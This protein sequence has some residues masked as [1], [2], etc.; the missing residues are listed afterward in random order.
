MTL[1]G[2]INLV[3]EGRYNEH[4]FYERWKMIREKVNN[5]SRID[6]CYEVI[7]VRKNH[8]V[9]SR[10]H[11]IIALKTGEMTPMSSVELESDSF[12]NVS[13]PRE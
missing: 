6:E 12:K 11:K 5:E 9:E 3:A 7:S 1:W 13:P 8:V 4:T 10:C 2:F